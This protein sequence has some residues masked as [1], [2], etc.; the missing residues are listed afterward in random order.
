M[1]VVTVSVVV[2]L[3]VVSEVVI[4]VPVVDVVGSGLAASVPLWSLQPVPGASLLR[5]MLLWLRC[6]PPVPPSR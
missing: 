2:V 5:P 6:R 3:G 4:A 1:V